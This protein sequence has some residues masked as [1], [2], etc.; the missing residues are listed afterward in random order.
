MIPIKPSHPLSKMAGLSQCGG[1]LDQPK[2]LPRTW[3]P[4]S[5]NY[6]DSLLVTFNECHM[7]Y[8]M[9]KRASESRMA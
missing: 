6:L 2:S 9:R 3:V 8:P 1:C 5:R 7:L 4:G